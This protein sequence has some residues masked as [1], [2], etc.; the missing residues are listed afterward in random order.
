MN[1]IEQLA[2]AWECLRHAV[3]QL[4][5]PTIWVPWLVLGAAEI[6][7]VLAC[8]GF[9]HPALS[10]LIAPLLLQVGGERA[11]HYPAIFRM[12][13]MLF[14]R[15]DLVIG[16]L[17][18]SLVTG[19]A[20]ALFAVRYAAE[21]APRDLWLRALGKAPA[22]VMVSVPAALL[23]LALSAW[24]AAFT[25]GGGRVALVVG[26]AGFGVGLVIQAWFVF[27][28]P[29]VVLGGRGW[30]GALAGLPRAAARGI[31][32]ALLLPAIAAAPALPFQQLARVGDLIVDRRPELMVA[33]MCGQI[34]AALLGAALLTGSVT[35]L[36]QSAVEPPMR[37]DEEEA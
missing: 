15:A 22:L 11:L 33:V 23:T 32:G 37:E 27:A 21:A 2:L 30:I 20:T 9:A 13:P 29:Y 18:G 36:F 16:L 25:A 26:V 12:L 34:A 8:A 6:A 19:V 10:W 4:R 7:A 3:D 24:L 28:V 17:L 5:R 14:A 1:P 31:V 35:L